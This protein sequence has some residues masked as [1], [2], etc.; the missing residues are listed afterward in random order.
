MKKR[1]STT[2]YSIPDEYL[3][4][5]KEQMEFAKEKL[6]A[7]SSSDTIVKIILNFKKAWIALELFRRLHQDF[8]AYEALWEKKE[9][10]ERDEQVVIYW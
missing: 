4:E 8:K 3:E 5:F 9:K 1:H 6:G 10:E 7:T 2:S